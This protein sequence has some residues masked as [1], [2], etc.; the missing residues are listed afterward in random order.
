MFKI[1]KT[2]DAEMINSMSLQIS[3]IVKI[4][5]RHSK[6][7]TEIYEHLAAPVETQ[8][9][10]IKPKIIN[11]IINGVQFYEYPN[12][13]KNSEPKVFTSC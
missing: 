1:K 5:D 8:I 3:Q 4:L 6:N 9:M 2:D 13:R 10:Q 7:I 12:Y 11:Q